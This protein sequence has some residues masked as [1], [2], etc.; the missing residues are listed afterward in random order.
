[1]REVSHDPR[2]AEKRQRRSSRL[3][4]KHQGV[5]AKR[6][7]SSKDSKVPKILK[8]T[9]STG[10]PKLETLHSPSKENPTVIKSYENS[11]NSK[12]KSSSK[13]SF[14]GSPD[15]SVGIEAVFAA[16]DLSD[17]SKSLIISMNLCNMKDT[18]QLSN[19]ELHD[20]SNLFSCKDLRDSTFQDTIIIVLCLGKCCQ[21]LIKEKSG[22][23]QDQILQEQ[24]IPST[25]QEETDFLDE[26][27]MILLKISMLHVT[28]YY[29]RMF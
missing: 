21:I 11:D 14:S 22:L 26:G 5:R 20:V 8:S 9:P 24:L 27:S 18:I 7:V 4:R 15:L 2:E 16:I 25:F 3:N 19:L 10:N 12:S 1:M 29:V 6:S 17:S 28:G 23:N 13:V